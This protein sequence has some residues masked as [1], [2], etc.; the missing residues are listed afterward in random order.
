LSVAL[1][2]IC[3]IFWYAYDAIKDSGDE[4]RAIF[5][6]SYQAVTEAMLMAIMLA[7]YL[8]D[9]TDWIACD[10]AKVAYEAANGPLG[11]GKAEPKTVTILGKLNPAWSGA[12]QIG[13]GL[14]GIGATVLSELVFD[15]AQSQ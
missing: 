5:V 8:T 4:T 2:V 1:G 15:K 3:E 7:E 11:L 14:I 12:G 9:T 10:A 13:L 6:L